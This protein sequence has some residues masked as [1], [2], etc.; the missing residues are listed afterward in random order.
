MN[1]YKSVLSL[2]GVALLITGAVLYAGP[3][4]PPAG[5]VSST[6]KTLTE[7]EPRTIINSINTPGD[8]DSL[9][10]ITQPGSYYLARGITGVVGKHGIEIASSGVTI[11][12]NGF[13]LVGVPAMGA[14]DGVSV[15]VAS[16]TDIAVVN[17]SIRNWGDEGVDLGSTA[18][19]NCRIER[20]LVSGNTGNGIYVG[21]GGTVSNCR[22]YDN[23][24]QGIA[25]QFGCTVSNCSVYQNT[26]S[27]INTDQGGKVMDCVAFS[28][29]AFG[30]TVGTGSIVADCVARS[31]TVDGIRCSSSCLISGNACS[32]NGAGG[33]DGAG[34]HATNNDNRI[35]GNNCTGADRGI[36]VDA[37][38]NIIIR[39]TCSGNTTN[40]WDVVAGN[41]ILVVNATNAAAVTGNSGGAAPGSTDPNANFTY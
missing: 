31:N 25:T 29:G 37:P 39:N 38:G 4:T 30:I 9:F 33:G 21:T 6:Y 35:E 27:G 34:I 8:A 14:F 40:N 19:V 7:V 41:V 28:N 12:L 22:A 20:V 13:D 11:D 24:G 26:G 18:A 32:G 23:A 17:G 5:P 1:Q 15:T 10:R 3:L 16:L 2:A 36:D